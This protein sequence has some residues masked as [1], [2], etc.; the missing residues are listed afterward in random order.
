[1]QQSKVEV[2][3]EKERKMYDEIKEG[4]ENSRIRSKS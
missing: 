1:M 4:Y 3:V 2:H